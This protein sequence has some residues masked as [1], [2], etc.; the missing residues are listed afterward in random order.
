[1]SIPVVEFVL[2]AVK[3]NPRLGVSSIDPLP[4]RTDYKTKPSASCVSSSST[5]QAPAVDVSICI[6]ELPENL[7]L[8]F[9]SQRCA[10][11]R[12]P[13]R[14]SATTIACTTRKSRSLYLQTV[15]YLERRP[16]P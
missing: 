9:E 2:P 1:M 5:S 12:E 4:G 7:S 3:R 16:E 8:G 11:S 13:K 14:I 15:D 10:L 6:G